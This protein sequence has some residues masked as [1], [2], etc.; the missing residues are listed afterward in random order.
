MFIQKENIKKFFKGE[1]SDDETTLAKYSRDTS[2]FEV[3]PA[4]TTFPKDIADIENLVQFV[5]QEKENDKNSKISIT[6]R[7]AGTDMSGG[8]LNESIILDFTKYFNRILKIGRSPA[9][10]S[11][12]AVAEPGV[13]YR[14][15]DKETMKKN[16]FLPSYPA[17]REICALGGMVSNNSG[18][19]K[20][21]RYGKTIDYVNEMEVVLNDGKKYALK[22]LVKSELD[23]KMRQKDFE[24]EIYRKTFDLIDK[25]YDLIQAARPKVSKNSAGYNLWD[26]WNGKIFNLSKLIVGSQG[27]LGILTKINFRLAHFSP[28]SGML[29]IFLKDLKSLADVVNVILPFKPTSLESFDDHTFRL[30]L[31]FFFGFIK[32][33]AKNPISLVLAFLPEFWSVLTRGMPKLVL[34]VEF[35]EEAREIVDR[36]LKDLNK[37]IVEKFGVE[38]R[39]AKNEKEAKKYWVIRRESFNLLR[40]RVKGKQTAPFVDDIIIRPEHLPEFLPKLYAIL[41][42]YEL[43]YTIAGH[44][45]DGNFHIIPLMK[46][47]DEK[48]RGKIK[49]AMDEVYNLVLEFKGSLTAEHNDGLI[50]SPYL[51][52]MF[53]PEV[54]KLFENIK[55]IFDPLGIFNPGKKVYSDISYALEHIKKS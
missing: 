45:G 7:S 22:P 33:L 44:V 28:H 30:A 51:K 4:L 9:D 52:Q 50:R 47:S 12:E 29:V 13:F 1:I 18:G 3:K 55:D 15:F 36:K 34:M 31:K 46:L 16:Y 23:E 38:T 2:L 37:T 5:R 14:D 6:A 8:P 27:T 48:E 11:P 21:L 19:E 32:L 17:S 25:N 39:I 10:S 26:V 24:G 53:G 35:E 41:D 40:Q 20:T 54:Y 42:K 43:F 49:P